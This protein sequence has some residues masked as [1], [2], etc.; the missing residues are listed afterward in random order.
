MPEYEV[1]PRDDQVKIRSSQCS[2]ISERGF[3][4]EDSQPPFISAAGKSNM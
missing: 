1:K 2:P 3:F 4:L